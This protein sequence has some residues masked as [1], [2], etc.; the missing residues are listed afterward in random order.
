MKKCRYCA[1]DIQDAAVKCK[2]CGEMVAEVKARASTSSTHDDAPFGAGGR[3]DA[4]VGRV[5]RLLL[6]LVFILVIG[7]WAFAVMT[8]GHVLASLA[9]IPG[10][11]L[12]VLATPL[13]W[14]IGDVVRQFVA[15]DM[16]FVRG[17]VKEL[18][19]AKLFWMYGPQSAG[20]AIVGVAG[21]I[22]FAMT[23]SWLDPLVFVERGASAGAATSA[24]ARASGDTTPTPPSREALGEEP[25]T[26]A[27]MTAAEPDVQSSEA[28]ASTQMSSTSTT[29]PPPEDTPPAESTTSG[30]QPIPSTMDAPLSPVTAPVRVGG[31]IR[32][33]TKIKDVKPVYPSIAESAR[34]QG[35]VIVEATI[36][37]DGTVSDARVIRSIPMLDEAALDAVRQWAFTP[38]LSNGVPVPVIMTMA[39]NF[40]LQ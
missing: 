18:A 16:Y 27:T 24:A 9:A 13:A 2:H 31:T 15:P 6:A 40:T 35:T 14:K 36:G 30:E 5:L 34:L 1:E 23:A 26:A 25:P 19:K 4:G 12:I 29:T 21:I 22:A 37:P 7:A 28:E 8:E 32:P 39:V 11:A 17:G 33:P 38:T 3:K 10:I 20:V